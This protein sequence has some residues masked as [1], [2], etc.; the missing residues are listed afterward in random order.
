MKELW[1][2][3]KQQTLLYWLAI[4]ILACYSFDSIATAIV[5]VMVDAEWHELT[6]TQKLIRVCL[7]T[8]AWS[9]TMLALFTNVSKKAQNN[10]LPFQDPSISGRTVQQTTAVTDFKSGPPPVQ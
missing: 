7:V 4:A 3:T 9:S 5:S 6:G 1:N 10:E 8:K 2:K